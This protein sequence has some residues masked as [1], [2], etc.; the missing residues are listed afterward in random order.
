MKIKNC[1]VGLLAIMVIYLLF[2][3]VAGSLNCF[4]WSEWTRFFLVLW[5]LI[6]GVSALGRD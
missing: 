4:E 3:F 6:A 2:S 1:I 5:V